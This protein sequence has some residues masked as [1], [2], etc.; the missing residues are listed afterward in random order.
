MD[1]LN[2]PRPRTQVGAHPSSPWSTDP[3]PKPPSIGDQ[4]MQMAL[5]TFRGRFA[6]LRLTPPVPA[7]LICPHCAAPMDL[8]DRDWLDRS[9]YLSA[10][11]P[12]CGCRRATTIELAPSATLLVEIPQEASFD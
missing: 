9:I 3:R 5:R 8:V 2:L 1:K 10:D 11:C 7:G 12:R 4:Q 6:T